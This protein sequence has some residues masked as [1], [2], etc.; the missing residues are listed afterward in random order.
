M[1]GKDA[2]A[3]AV[4]RRQHLLEEVAEID[5]FLRLFDKYSSGVL[6]DIYETIDQNIGMPQKEF[7]IFIRNILRNAGSPLNS[8]QILGLMKQ[9]KA[10]IGGVDELRNLTTKL[11]RARAEIVR[12]DN[13]TYWPRDLPLLQEPDTT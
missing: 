11:W 8:R 6:E 9:L 7:T 10:P 12:L 1:S 13:R 3:N 2:Y 4:R 5:R